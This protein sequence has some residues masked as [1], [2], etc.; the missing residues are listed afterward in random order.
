MKKRQDFESQGFTLVELMIV[1]V[2]IGLLASFAIPA[3]N[4]T[5]V[6]SRGTAFLNDLRVFADAADTYEGNPIASA[7]GLATIAEI[8]ERDLCANARK[9]GSHL[10][11]GLEGLR[12]HEI[13]GDIRGK[14][15]FFGI[16]FV[17]NLVTKE[18]FS[19]DIPIATLIGKRA[20]AKGLL[21]RY[22]P[23]WMSLG[24]PLILTQEQADDIVS[25]LDA[26]ITEVLQ[27]INN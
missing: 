21:T 2:I 9:V 18:K 22:D 11:E 5:R 6:V 1:V 4:R 16:E 25:I 23:Q 27:E 26:S 14:G 19:D 15:L 12:K 24:P 13:I 7:A 8:I 3:F 10:R 17:R 20:L